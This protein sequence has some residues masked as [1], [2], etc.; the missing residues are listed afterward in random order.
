MLVERFTNARGTL[1][2]VAS[3]QNAYFGTAAAY[4]RT[5]SEL[6]AA[7]YVLLSR[8]GT[9]LPALGIDTAAY[10]EGSAPR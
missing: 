3:A 10:A 7:R 1:F 5:L 8:T 4:I 6:D 2:D 9:L